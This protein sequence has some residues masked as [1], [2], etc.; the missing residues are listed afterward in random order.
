MQPKFTIVTLSKRQKELYKE[1]IFKIKYSRNLFERDIL[2]IRMSEERIHTNALKKFRKDFFSFTIKTKDDLFKYLFYILILVLLVALPILSLE[3]GVSQTEICDQQ[4]AEQFYNHFTSSHTSVEE[5]VFA[6]NHP[7]FVDF[8]CCCICKWFGIDGI[9]QFRH[10][11]GAFFA[12]GIIL[13]AGGFLMKLFTWRAAFFGTFMLF[14]SPHFL[15]QSF[16]NVAGISFTFFYLLGIYEIYLFISEFPV[17]KWKRLALISLATIAA[18]YVN[19]AGFVL[20]H[21]FILIAFLIFF[22]ENPFRNLFTRAYGYNFLKLVAIVAS[23]VVAVYLADLLNPLHFLK[24]SN[25]G[26]SN[27]VVKSAENLPI[28]EFLWGGKMTTSTSLGVRFLLMKMQVTIP[29]VIIIGG[30]VHLLFVRTVVKEAHVFPAL[31]L[32]FSVF[33]PLWS[34]YR[35]GSSVAD[36]WSYYL[37]LYPLVVILSAAGYDG[38]LRRVDDRYTNAVIVAGL[39]LL[40]LLPLRHVLLNQPGIGI[41]YNELSGGLH[42]TFGKYVID[43]GHNYNRKACKWLIS[44]IH[45]ND[46]RYRTDTL[47]K[48]QIAT[49]DVDATRYF[50][51]NDTGRIEVVEMPLTDTPR[52]WDYY[53]SYIDDIP[54]RVLKRRWADSEDIIK[55]FKTDSKPVTIVFRTIPDTIAITTDTLAIDSIALSQNKVTN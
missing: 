29:L 26:M 7:Q 5:N 31:L 39:L 4:Q 25:S 51:R 23:T 24:F 50:F 1:L 28:R 10:V 43:E 16:G 18:V 14:I 41:Y 37:M 53:L 35:T 17:V 36:G 44:Y 52:C 55:T 11:I 48:L 12:W 6:Q 3:T 38:F 40:S 19:C 49:L 13:L 30:L 2:D 45:T 42:N 15:A 47:P 21:Y 20:L 27:A 33:F 34:L 46:E 54:P 9:Y 8:V 22:I 32:Y